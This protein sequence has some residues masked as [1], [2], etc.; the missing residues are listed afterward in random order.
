LSAYCHPYILHRSKFL[1]HIRQDDL[2]CAAVVANKRSNDCSPSCTGNA[3]VITLPN[4]TCAGEIAEEPE[5]H[6]LEAYQCITGNAVGVGPAEADAVA[7]CIA[8]KV[9]AQCRELHR[10]IELRECIHV[11]SRTH[12]LHFR[13]V[14]WWNDNARTE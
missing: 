1:W 10:E 2:H 12:P 14:R 7:Q 5:T 6:T 9:R 11:H 4:L 13:A 3:I 8:N